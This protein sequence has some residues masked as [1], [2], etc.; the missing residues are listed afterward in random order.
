MIHLSTFIFT[1]IIYTFIFDSP[2]TDEDLSYHIFQIVNSLLKAVNVIYKLYAP[3]FNLIALGI[4]AYLSFKIGRLTI[5][6]P[7]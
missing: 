4:A 6:D 7:L 3:L 5:A 2:M 1:Y